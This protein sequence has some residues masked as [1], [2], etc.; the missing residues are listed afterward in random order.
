MS[1]DVVF[2]ENFLSTVSYTQ[3]HV[4]GGV[5]NQ[6][7]SHPAFRAGQNIITTEDPLRFSSNEDAP[8]IHHR[9]CPRPYGRVLHGQSTSFA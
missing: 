6:P 4:P 5:L 8:G 3:S 2:D 9:Q 1:N 7:P